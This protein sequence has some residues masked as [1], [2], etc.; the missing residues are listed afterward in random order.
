MDKSLPAENRER[1]RS[2]EG[3]SREIS[4]R[5]CMGADF[6]SDQRKSRED[7]WVE[8]CRIKSC[9]PYFISCLSNSISRN[10]P[11]TLFR[12]SLIS[13]CR[14]GHMVGKCLASMLTMFW[15][16]RDVLL[17]EESPTL[18][19][20]VVETNAKSNSTSKV[21]PRNKIGL[22]SQN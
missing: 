16:S 20:S 1:Q 8:M 3:Y 6:S 14:D 13:C 5:P 7:L 22:E 17:K 10:D 15:Q 19:A 9:R 11:L 12:T 18:A 2:G 21:R 4:F